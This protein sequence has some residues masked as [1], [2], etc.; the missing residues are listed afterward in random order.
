AAPS[1]QIFP[2]NGKIVAKKGGIVSF[3]CK[4]NG[5][6]G[7]IIQWSKKDGILPSGLQVQSGYVLNF[8]EVRRQDAGI[9][10]CTAS[11]GIGQPVTGEIKLHVLYPPEVSVLRSWVNSGE[12]LEAKLDCIVHA[13]PPAEMNVSYHLPG[14][15][16]D[17][18]VKPSQTY[19][20]A[21]CE[22]TQSFLIK[23]LEADSVYEVLVQTKNQHG[24]GE[25][26]DMHQWFTSRRG[27]PF[28]HSSAYRNTVVCRVAFI[29][30]FLFAFF[31]ILTS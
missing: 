20:A 27:G 17:L 28:V 10:Q 12:G 21:S 19:N 30:I 31:L 15:W 11:N 2:Q 4:A 8:N 23:N 24:F 13:D 29:L 25:L 18:S 26:S 7:P 1:I 16:H 5:N 14:Q 22:R 3:E 6:P 9:Y